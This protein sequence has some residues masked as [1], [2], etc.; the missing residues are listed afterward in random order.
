MHKHNKW[1][2]LLSET[3][4]LCH[5]SYV[6]IYFGLVS[7]EWIQYPQ[8]KWRHFKVIWHMHWLKHDLLLAN[9]VLLFVIFFVCVKNVVF[10]GLFFYTFQTGGRPGKYGQLL[11]Q[12][13]FAVAAYLLNKRL[14]YTTELFNSD[15]IV[16]FIR[17]CLAKISQ[18]RVKR[19]RG[20]IGKVQTGYRKY[21]HMCLN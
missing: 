16:T 4:E 11:Q 19:D 14:W 8:N 2:W 6:R 7:T 1:T 20:E 10:L 12:R 5:L 15:I 21:W 13:H 3:A 17:L 18:K 9:Y